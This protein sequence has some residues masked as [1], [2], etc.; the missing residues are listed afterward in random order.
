MWKILEKIFGAPTPAEKAAR[1]LFEERY[2]DEVCMTRIAADEPDRVVVGVY[3]HWN[4]KPP[5]FRHFAVDKATM[6]VAELADDT[7]YRPKNWR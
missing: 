4:G 2:A 1:A 5:R 6:A 3:Y 7:G